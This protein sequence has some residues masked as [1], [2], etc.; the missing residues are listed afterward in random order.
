MRI[1]FCRVSQSAGYYVV[2]AELN[3]A[4]SMAERALRLADNANQPEL[5]VGAHYAM[6]TTVRFG[7]DYVAAERSIA[8]RG[9]TSSA[10]RV[11]DGQLAWCGGA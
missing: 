2:G 9:V 1:E 11:A 4:L 3:E 8:R 10:R 6:G 7:G 5:R